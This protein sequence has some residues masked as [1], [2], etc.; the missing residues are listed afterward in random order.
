MSSEYPEEEHSSQRE[1]TILYKF[2]EVGASLDY[3]DKSK[4]TNVVGYNVDNTLYVV[5][6]EC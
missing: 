6:A 3:S 5:G 4:E 2:P 1:L